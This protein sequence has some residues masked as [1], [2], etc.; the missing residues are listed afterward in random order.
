MVGFSHRT[1]A[2]IQLLVNSPVVDSFTIVSCP[3]LWKI[4]HLCPGRYRSTNCRASDL[5]KC[6][7]SPAIFDT[8]FTLGSALDSCVAMKE[9]RVVLVHHATHYDGMCSVVGAHLGQ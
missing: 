5:L 4:I 6:H 3:Y 7:T 9:L 8:L 1:H 2:H